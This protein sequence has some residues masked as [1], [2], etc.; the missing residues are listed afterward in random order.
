MCGRVWSS[1]APSPPPLKSANGLWLA[2]T[3]V[4]PPS[5]TSLSVPRTVRTD[6]REAGPGKVVFVGRA[7]LGGRGHREAGRR[8]GDLLSFRRSLHRAGRRRPARE[9]L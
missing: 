9:Y 5:G 3:H 8:I 2:V 4:A 6:H 1:H 7:A